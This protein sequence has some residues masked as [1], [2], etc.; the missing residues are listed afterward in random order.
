MQT[1]PRVS[2]PKCPHAP[3]RG[4]PSTPPTATVLECPGA[5]IKESAGGKFSWEITPRVLA[6]PG[7][8]HGAPGAPV[9][10]RGVRT[11][12]DDKYAPGQ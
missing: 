5:P 11:G 10:K 12:D 2:V 6:F 3:L 1:P 4:V 8:V 9:K 7:I